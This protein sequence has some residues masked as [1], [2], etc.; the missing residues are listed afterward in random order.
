MSKLIL[1]SPI[2]RFTRMMFSRVIERLA[3]VISEE[4]LSFSQVAAL[5]IIDQEQSITI[6]DISQRLNLSLSATSR[7]IDDLVKTDFI[8][9]LEDQENR[10]SKILTL[11]SHGQSFIDK[12]SVERVKM[13]H[14]TT[15]S[16]PQ[17]LSTKVLSA[18]SLTQRKKP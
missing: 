11:T 9:R 16:L 1:H 17:K 5:H 8:D 13:I 6:Q 2:E 18:L 3:L 7:L 12:L 10:R 14:S 4:N 15:E